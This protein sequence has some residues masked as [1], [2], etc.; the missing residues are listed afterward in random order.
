M[1]T[2]ESHQVA[3]AWILFR[4]AAC[5]SEACSL[6]RRCRK[7][8]VCPPVKLPFRRCRV[9][10]DVLASLQLIGI[11]RTCHVKSKKCSVPIELENGPPRL[12]HLET[13]VNE[14]VFQQ[15]LIFVMS[16]LA[17]SNAKRC[18]YFGDTPPFPAT[19]TN[20]GLSRIPKPKKCKPLCGATGI[21][22]AGVHPNIV[23]VL[24]ANPK[25]PP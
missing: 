3:R 7:Q 19:V 11:S 2:V 23:T 8:N 4:V 25:V 10:H 18:R 5:L 9:N 1:E 12:I 15:T 6:A 20:E 21:L 14:V 22:A 16:F 13:V 24:M 17:E